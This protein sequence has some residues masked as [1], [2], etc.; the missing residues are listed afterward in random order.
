MSNPEEPFQQ[1][2]QGYSTQPVSPAQPQ[3]TQTPPAYPAAPPQIPTYSAPPQQT[4][5]QQPYAQQPYYQSPF[6]AQ[7]VPADFKNNSTLYIVLSVLEILFASWI[8]G[9][10]ALIFAI[11]FRTNVGNH[12]YIAAAKSKKNARIALIVGLV[13]GIVGCICLAFYYVVLFNY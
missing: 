13:I 11:Q 2:T 3:Y 6:P 10:I 1:D 12:D 4:Y 7:P 8:P 9:I 5:T